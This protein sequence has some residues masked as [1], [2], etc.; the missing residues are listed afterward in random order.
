MKRFATIFI[1]SCAVIACAPA[2]IRAQSA[3][4]KPAP[5]TALPANGL[6]E[7]RP[8]FMPGQVLRYQMELVTITEGSSGGVVQ[9]PQ[10]PSRLVVTWDATVRIE[11]LPADASSS[12]SATPPSAQ[13]PASPA[14]LHLRMTYEKSAATIQTDGFD[15]TASAIQDQYQRLQG[16]AVDFSLDAGG[17]VTDISGGDDVFATPQAARDAQAWVAQLSSGFA[18]PG[19]ASAPGQQWS[20]DE[21]A[22]GIP[23]PDMIWHTD[24]SYLRNESCALNAPPQ[25][26][27]PSVAGAPPSDTQSVV[28]AQSASS[29]PA[30][31]APPPTASAYSSGETCAVIDTRVSLVPSK[32]TQKAENQA[33]KNSAAQPNSNASSPANVPKGLHT[34]GTWTG[35]SESLIYVSIRTGWVVSIAQNGDEQM[36]VTVTSDRLDSMRY[37][38]KVHSH[39]DL[40]LLPN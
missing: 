5:P 6:V 38:G 16:H 35:A 26:L 12:A 22:T 27:A 40:A 32:A 1:L 14:A 29:P 37:A 23:L 25:A 39:V 33:A 2:G 8:K 18:P 20:S 21:P 11:V 24:S 28:S 34:T 19:T 15:P 3:A 10:G 17:K 13:S 7:L 30:G 9:D 31:S 36:D 4:Q